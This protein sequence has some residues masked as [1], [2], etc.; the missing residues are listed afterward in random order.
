MI[1]AELK[2]QHRKKGWMSDYQLTQMKK[3]FGWIWRGLRY[4]PKTSLNL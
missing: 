3:M 1:K 4:E 2:P